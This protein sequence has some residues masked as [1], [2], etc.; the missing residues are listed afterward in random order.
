ML[1]RLIAYYLLLLL[2]FV[3]GMV[4]YKKLA[5]PYKI[6]S[7]Y[8]GVTLL[9]EIL[10]RIYGYMYRNNMPVEHISSYSEFIFNAVIFYQ[11]L[12][13]RTLKKTAMAVIA[14]VTL[15]F[16]INS[17][18]LQPYLHSFPSNA[19]IIS[20]MVLV[21]FSLLVFKQML[22]Y[23]LQVNITGQSIFWYNTAILFYST[24]VF[25]T[26][27][28]VNYVVKHHLSYDLIYLCQLILNM[29]FYILLGIAIFIEDKKITADNA[30]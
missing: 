11:L 14:A 25:L 3:L 6:L 19:I 28:L 18:W 23:P 30:G 10:S 8:V 22:Q 17:L 24:T 27:G 21:V 1:T 15:F 4:R 2:I 9:L 20:E 13:N 26:F 7:F 16:I 29:I 12:K 5:V